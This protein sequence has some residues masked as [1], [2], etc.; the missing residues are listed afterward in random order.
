MELN[1][2]VKH[3]ANQFDDTDPS[4]ISAETSFRDLDEWSSLISLSVLNMIEKK[5]VV[6]FTFDDMRNANTVQ[7]LYDIV[8]SK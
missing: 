3:F 6:N 2:F 5:C 7:D 1:E 4:E 8:T